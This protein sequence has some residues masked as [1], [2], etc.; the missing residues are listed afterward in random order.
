MDLPPVAFR[1]ATL[2]PWRPGDEALAAAAEPFLSAASLSQRF[3]AGTGGRLPAAY[4]RHVAKGARPEWDAQVAAAPGALLGWAEFGRAPG[5]RDTADLAVLVADPWHRQGIA[6]ALIRSLIPRMAAAGVRTL[7]ADVLPSNQAAQALLR[8]IFEPDLRYVYADG[9]VRY[10]APVAD[11]AILMT[12]KNAPYGSAT[13]A[14]RPTGMS[15]GVTLTE[16]PSS[17]TL[18]TVAS[19]SATAK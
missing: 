18:A 12:E 19:Q 15:N 13:I 9:V 17:A 10:A 16:P 11:A 2:R 5:E 7:H 14:I 1:P 4:L 8:S 3:L 6:S